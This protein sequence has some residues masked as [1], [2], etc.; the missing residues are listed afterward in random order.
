[1]LVAVINSISAGG[2]KGHIYSRESGTDEVVKT[3]IDKSEIV[4]A[5]LD[6]GG[7]VAV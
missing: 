4:I 3:D 5:L 2:F 1:M 7:R 6:E